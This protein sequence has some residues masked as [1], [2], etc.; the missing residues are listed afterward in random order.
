MIT[1]VIL[2]L[3]LVQELLVVNME[4]IEEFDLDSVLEQFDGVVVEGGVDTDLEEDNCAGG[5]CKI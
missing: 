3:V 1:T 5:A 4:D 2:L